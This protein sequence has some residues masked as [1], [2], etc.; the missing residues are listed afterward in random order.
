M[1]ET[2]PI[3][4]S[5]NENFLEQPQT[6]RPRTSKSQGDSH[7]GPRT[8]NDSI[9]Q[10]GRWKPGDRETNGGQRYDGAGEHLA[11]DDPDSSRWIHRDKLALIESREMQQAGIDPILRQ[12]A[13]TASGRE[14]LRSVERTSNSV[15]T[16]P[17]LPAARED[18]YNRAH[19]SQRHYESKEDSLDSPNNFELRTPEEILANHW[20]EETH[21]NMYRQPG[22]RASSSRI[23]LST[24]SPMPVPHEHIARST[25]L[26]RKR[27]TSGNWS[28]ADEDGISYHKTRSRNHSV[29]SQTVPDSPQHAY[30][31]V[32][33]AGSRPGS[34]DTPQTSPSKP[35]IISITKPD[36]LSPRKTSTASR[37]ISGVTKTRITSTGSRSSPSQRPTTRSGPNDRPRTAVNRPEGDAPW[38]ATMYKPDP[39]LPPDKQMLPTHAKRLQQE[40]W[41]REGKSS[42][43][44][45]RDFSPLAVHTE[46]GLQRPPTP[47][48]EPTPKD[49]EKAPEE[50]TWPLKSVRRAP[51]LESRPSTGTD[52]AGYS[53]IPR[54]QTTPSMSANPSPKP[55]ATPMR[56]EE[57]KK[58]KGCAC[59]VV[60]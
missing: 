18:I 60:M 58:E 9:R 40:Q 31:T 25:P 19:S 37:N 41:D 23:P 14:G 45:D 53:T 39:H 27:G 16:G 10:Y 42:S 36:T 52:H 54:V 26:Q 59:C 21:P 47:R 57:A 51:T 34:R 48:P 11:D 15:D 35:R 50:Q 8:R 22:L 20:P 17:E 55:K 5:L 49:P 7:N 33:P 1:K 12:K 4:A 44:S 13:V 56:V 6:A 29:G 3:A 38:L 28:G 43:S 2:R 24:S 32:T 30:S 46:H